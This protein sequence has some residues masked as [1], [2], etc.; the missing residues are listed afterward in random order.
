M[1]FVGLGGGL[2]AITRYALGNL[3]TSK[4]KSFFP[5]GT[6]FIN[7]TGSI[8]LGLVNSLYLKHA[9]STNLWLFIGIGFLGGYTTF[10]TFGYETIQL[11]IAKKFNIALYYVLLSTIT[12]ICGAYIGYHIF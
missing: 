5:F 11:I 8:I 1:I 4:T 2:G 10:S 12:S 3:I 9:I 6:F 7:L